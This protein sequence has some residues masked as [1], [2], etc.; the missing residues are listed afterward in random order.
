MLPLRDEGAINTYSYSKNTFINSAIEATQNN[1]SAA[2]LGSFS[3]QL[4]LIHL[5][6]TYLLHISPGGNISIVSHF[7]PVYYI[8]L[9]AP[10][11]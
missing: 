5:R 7:Q 4:M 6:H 1:R 11:L 3:Y 10:Q 9:S 2:E 8:G